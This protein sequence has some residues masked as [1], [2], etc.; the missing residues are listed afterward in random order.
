ML[1]LIDL[2]EDKCKKNA[3]FGELYCYILLVVKWLSVQPEKFIEQSLQD[4]YG[5]IKGT[6]LMIFD[7]TGLNYVSR[8]MFY[9]M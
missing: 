4:L 6:P 5:W 8:L 7:M 3:S 1:K 9:L 2:I